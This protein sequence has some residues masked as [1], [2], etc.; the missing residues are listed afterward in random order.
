M[1]ETLEP[2]LVPSGSS[3]GPITASGADAP[4]VQP[5]YELIGGTGLEPLGWGTPSPSG[6]SPS[7]IA[8]AYG[9]RDIV[10]GSIQG[11]GAGQTIAIVD[12]YD[13]PRLVN[14]SA[15][16]Y[17]ASD[18]AA[19]D[20]EYGLPDPPSFTKINQNGATV[21]LPGVDPAG[22]GNPTGNWELEEALDVEWAHAMAPA[23]SIV[24]VECSSDSGLDMYQG[25]ITAANLPG[26]SVVSMSWGSDEFAGERS[27]DS[28]FTTPTGH[29]GVTFVASTGDN[30]SPGEY[31]AYSPDVVAVG[32][33][34]LYLTPSG[35]YQSESGWSGSGGG[36]S[37]YEPEPAYQDGVQSLGKRTIPDVAF[38]ANPSTGV[39]VYDTYNN[40]SARPWEVV[41]GTSLAAPSVA[42]LIA[43]A[44]QGRASA[45]MPT[46]SGPTQTLAALYALPTTDFRDITTGSNGQSALPGYD[47]VTGLGTPKAQLLV[48]DLAAYGVAG[49][50]VVMS[51]PASVTAGTPFTFTVRA[52]TAS[53]A[54]ARGFDGSVTVAL[55]SGPAGG[56]LHGNLT[57]MALNGM[58]TVAGLSIDQAGSYT[59]VARVGASVSV[60]SASFAAVPAAPARVAI[61]DEPPARVGVG[62]AFGMEVAVLDAFGNVVGSYSGV[63]TALLEHG[64]AGA[65]L[66]GTLAVSVNQGYATFQALT[67]SEAVPT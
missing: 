27:F 40:P 43:V 31:P 35:Q 23:A 3:I 32:G 46:L 49:K 5:T 45:G 17:S 8:A 20:R 60:H 12:A 1:L 61:I 9:T 37:A 34:S 67:V 66:G 42:G 58:A 24:L 44:D 64:P 15:P 62:D 14:T 48:P 18:L 13:D 29:P 41:G 33:T 59:L 21:P 11:N 28:D 4:G 36:V 25:V 6:Y 7:Q 16:G 22:P 65:T 56:V 10:F 2:R 52:E 53:G 54:P 50:L 51:Q 63:V 38:D 47:E 26:V 55:A 19:F 57:V 30:G 39:S